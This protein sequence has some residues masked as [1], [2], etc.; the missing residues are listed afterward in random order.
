[1]KKIELLAP[2]GS[3]EK[4]KYAFAYGAD[5]VYLG[6]PA[7]SMRCR[8]NNFTMDQ[9]QEA[10]EYAHS[11]KKKIYVTINIVAHNYHLKEVPKHLKLLNSWRPDGIIVSDPGMMELVKKYAPKCD[12][13]LSTQANA[14]NW[15]TVKFW[16]K[17]GV[18]RVVLGREVSIEEIKEI[19][20]QAPGV[21]IEHF[22][23]GAM[24]MSYSGRC[25]L[26]AWLS[27]RSANL[28]DC[29]QPCRWKYNPKQ[30]ELNVISAEVE[31][32]MRPGMKIPLEEDMNGTYILNSKDLC[33]IEYLPEII[34]AGVISLKIEGRTKSAAYVATVIKAYREALDYLK[35]HAAP[36]GQSVPAQNLAR[37]RSI[38]KNVLDNLVHRGYTV[39]FAF[40][41][42]QVEQ[43]LSDSHVGS[44]EQFVGEIAGVAK[45][46]VAPNKKGKYFIK[47]RAHNAIR[48]GD[49][50]RIM[51]PKN[52]DIKFTIKKLYNEKGEEVESAHGGTGKDMFF[53]SN[54]A[55]ENLSI[56]FKIK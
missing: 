47:F 11:L 35:N 41:R 30:V 56:M 42:G 20:K 17:Q 54:K 55:V 29:V 4:M 32:P 27:S 1:M 51:Q 38:K 24:C 14:T 19:H 39:G 45:H 25:L 2:A 5:A 13:H 40:G 9:V 10:I 8:V 12:I 7:F 50:I 15:A 6:V 31:E 21:E 34:A 48:L 3:I 44:E 16:K 18:K 53:E 37:L 43:N 23:H 33:L 26:S 36:G 46:P 52:K 49:V 22:V 28:G